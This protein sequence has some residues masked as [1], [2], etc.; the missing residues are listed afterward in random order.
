MFFSVTKYPTKPTHPINANK[1]EGTWT[2]RIV[3]IL[4]VKTKTNKT[5]MTFSV[6]RPVEIH[7]K[8][9]IDRRKESSKPY[10]K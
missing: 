5:A 1:T 2:Y 3:Q 4:E 9:V 8:S 10:A 7:E 6:K